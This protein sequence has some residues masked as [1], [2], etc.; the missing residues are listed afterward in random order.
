MDSTTTGR[1]WLAG[2]ALAG[3]LAGCALGPLPPARALDPGDLPR[4]AGSW[5]WAEPLVSPAR[6]GSGPIRVRIADGRLRFEAPA[7]VGSL[8][9][10]EG[11]DRRVLRGEARERLDG[12]T[13]PVA[14]RQRPDRAGRAV[15]GGSPVLV[16]LGE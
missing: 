1:A 2:V 5:E 12:R 14:L 16:V 8:T 6:L 10:H 4:L 11:P 13:F 7:A 3:A 9:L 15:A